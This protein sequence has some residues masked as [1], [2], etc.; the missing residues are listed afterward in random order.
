MII[1]VAM[2]N[3]LEWRRLEAEKL[4]KTVAVTQLKNY[5]GL[6][7]CGGSGYKDKGENG[8]NKYLCTL[9]H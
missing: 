7:S 5:S 9:R 1:L 2:K 6:E 4:I 3:G 8:F